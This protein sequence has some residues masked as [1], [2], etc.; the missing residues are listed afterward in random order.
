MG[1][2]VDS[3]KR[4][5]KLSTTNAKSAK[6]SLFISINIVSGKAS[7]LFS[8]KTEDGI[9]PPGTFSSFNRY[10]R[11]FEKKKKKRKHSLDS[12]LDFVN[13]CYTSNQESI[14]QNCWNFLINREIVVIVDLVCLKEMNTE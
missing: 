10:G 3:L 7:R 8:T 9:R 14:E 1:N 2:R 6:C 12:P 11:H 13:F 4:H 5:G